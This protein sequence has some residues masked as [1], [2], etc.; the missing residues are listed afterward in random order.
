MDMPTRKCCPRCHQKCHRFCSSFVSQPNHPSHIAE[1][2][3]KPINR[4][5]FLNCTLSLGIERDLNIQVTFRNDDFKK[6]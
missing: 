1:Q 5:D 6:N 4:A 2:N 3:L